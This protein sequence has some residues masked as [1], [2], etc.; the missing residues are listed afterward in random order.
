MAYAREQVHHIFA[1]ALRGLGR[2][3]PNEDRRLKYLDFVNTY[4]QVSRKNPQRPLAR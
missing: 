2:M 1:R 3:E 4:S